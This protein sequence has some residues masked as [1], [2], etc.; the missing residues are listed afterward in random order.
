MSES[1]QQAAGSA[2]IEVR[3]LRTTLGGKVIFD[4]IDLDI[5]RGRITAIMGP[6]GTGK[7]TLLRHITGQLAPDSGSVVLQRGAS[8]RVERG[9]WF[10]QKQDLRV[11]DEG[12]RQCQ[13]LLHAFAEAAR[14]ICAPVAQVEQ[15]EHVFGA[16]VRVRH[17]VEPCEQA[18]V[19]T[20]AQT[21]IQGWRFG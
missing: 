3:G 5:A 4:G 7:T 17:V 9:G 13:P 1:R 2:L 14:F 21:L 16:L 11:M 8:F 6:S 10:I 18:Q 15:P 20:G 12:A 19:I